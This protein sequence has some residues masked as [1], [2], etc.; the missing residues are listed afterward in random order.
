MT[1]TRL[2]MHE[3]GQA[4]LLPAEFRFQGEEVEVRRETDGS[5]IVTP[6]E[7]ATGS[8]ETDLDDVFRKLDELSSGLAE[9]FQGDWRDQP[10]IRPKRPSRKAAT[11]HVERQRAD[12]L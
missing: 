5:L 12:R 9:C 3:G 4:V 11:E 2:F 6:V 1:R 7:T 10:M 8:S